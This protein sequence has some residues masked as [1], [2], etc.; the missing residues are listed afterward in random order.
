MSAEQVMRQALESIAANTCCGT[1]QE[2]AI[3]AKK[4]LLAVA[5]VQQSASPHNI[6]SAPCKYCGCGVGHMSWCRA[7]G[8]TGKPSV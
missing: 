3:V 5:P 8:G 6:E 7:I 1:C 4:A 2:A